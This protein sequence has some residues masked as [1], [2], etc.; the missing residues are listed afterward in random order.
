MKE[1]VNQVLSSMLCKIKAVCEGSEDGQARS[2]SVLLVKSASD[3]GLLFAQAASTRLYSRHCLTET[4]TSRKAEARICLPFPQSHSVERS[5]EGSTETESPL[6]L[7]ARNGNT[8]T[9]THLFE[10]P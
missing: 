10:K 1:L 2:M 4:V 6:S 3:S 8:S 9:T 5:T 7:Q